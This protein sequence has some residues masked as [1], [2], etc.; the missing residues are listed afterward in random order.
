MVVADSVFAHFCCKGLNVE[1]GF[2]KALLHN[3]LVTSHQPH[4]ILENSMLQFPSMTKKN[5]FKNNYSQLDN[6]L[7]QLLFVTACQSHQSNSLSQQAL[8]WL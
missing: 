4:S 2:F 7:C 3:Y 8:K 1:K 5:N 6:L